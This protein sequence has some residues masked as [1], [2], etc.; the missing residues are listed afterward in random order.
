MA[1]MEPYQG[2]K[3]RIEFCNG[4]DT[5]LDQALAG[6]GQV[7]H[8]AQAKAKIRVLLEQLADTGKLKTPKA[9]NTEAPLPDSAGHFYAVKHHELHAYGWYSQAHPGTFFVSHFTYKNW[10]K[11]RDADTDRVHRHWHSKED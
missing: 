2:L 4:C 8:R 1:D 9:F 10:N 11:L 6:F 7:K 3:L 5:S